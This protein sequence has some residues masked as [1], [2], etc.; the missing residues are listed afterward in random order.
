[1]TSSHASKRSIYPYP[2]FSVVLRDGDEWTIEVE[3][4][5]GG[6]EQLGKFK[7]HFDARKWVDN[8][9]RSWMRHRRPTKRDEHT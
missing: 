2:L 6:I 8:E 7:S 9:S 1:M 5:D 4:A 3:L